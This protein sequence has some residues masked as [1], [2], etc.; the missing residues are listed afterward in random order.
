VGTAIEKNDDSLAFV[1]KSNLTLTRF[2]LVVAAESADDD[3]NEAA[4]DEVVG[5]EKENVV[6]A[7]NDWVEDVDAAAEV[8]GSTKLNELAPIPVGRH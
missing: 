3:T 1:M 2:A 7:D 4:D 5:N 8:V 6:G